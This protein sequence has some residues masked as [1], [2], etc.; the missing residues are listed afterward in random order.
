MP[1]QKTL[2]GAVSNLKYI[3]Q[4]GRQLSYTENPEKANIIVFDVG[5]TNV[6][7]MNTDFP[8][9]KDG[10]DVEVECAVARSGGLEVGKL[11]NHTTGVD[12]QF[13]VK[14]ATWGSL[15]K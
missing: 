6:S 3:V 12:W 13:S 10:D 14:R 2:R 11:H 15:F 5:G 4:T 9:M 8:P 1:D 7:A